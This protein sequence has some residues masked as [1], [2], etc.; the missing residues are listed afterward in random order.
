MHY[1][2]KVTIERHGAVRFKGH[3]AGVGGWVIFSTAAA[4]T[5]RL[6]VVH[7][8]FCCNDQWIIFLNLFP[9]TSL[10]TLDSGQR[11]SMDACVLLEPSVAPEQCRMRLCSEEVQLLY[12]VSKRQPW[13]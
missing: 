3:T 8:L 2:V 1:D 13:A 11:V 7:S 9:V 12:P 6:A 4:A 10:V 5:E